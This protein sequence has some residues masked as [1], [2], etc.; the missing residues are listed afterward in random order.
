MKKFIVIPVI[1]CIILALIFLLIPAFRYIQN[2]FTWGE[3]CSDE[4]AT[5]WKSEDG[6]LSVVINNSK[7]IQGRG[8]YKGIYIDSGGNEYEVMF[9]ID[10]YADVRLDYTLNNRILYG[11]GRMNYF[12]DTYT[13]IVEEAEWENSIYK[14]GDEVVLRKQKKP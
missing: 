8:S 14:K 7:G 6:N 3:T 10:G 12:A 1:V 2:Y 4:Y 11:K 13:I 5:E 9:D